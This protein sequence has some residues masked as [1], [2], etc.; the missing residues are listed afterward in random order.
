ML[1]GKRM[2]FK[3]TRRRFLKLSGISTIAT[4]LARFDP[5]LAAAMVKT[6]ETDFPV[7]V[8]TFD[9]DQITAPDAVQATMSLATDLGWLTEG[10]SVFVKVACNSDYPPPSVTSPA[11]VEGVVK[12]LVEAGAGTVYVG[13]MSG[14]LF[15]RH[16]AER[17]FGSTRDNLRQTG[18]LEAAESAGAIIHCFEEVPFDEAYLPGIPEG[19]HHWGEDLQVAAILDQVDHIINL[20]RL[21]KH[22]LAGMTLGMKSGIGWIS[23]YSRMVLHRDADTFQEKI[24]EVNAIPQIAEKTRLTMTLVDKALTTYGPDAGYHLPLA[25]P[26]VIASEDVVSHDQIA[27]VTLLW[28]RR[29]T[30]QEIR[31]QVPYPVQANDFNAYFVRTTW[32][33]EAAAAYKNLLTYDDLADGDAMTH[34]NYAF[35]LL[36]GGRPDKIEVVPS[37]LELDWVLAEMLIAKPELNIVICT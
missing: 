17:G 10:D 25:H 8:H 30:P 23:D 24:A 19:D 13:D 26:L 1:K 9:P 32:G 20:P 6:P 15:V 7:H 31:D 11:V 21:G 5:G 28:G 33:D 37:G 36:H 29:Q 14:A 16:L 27:L 3:L 18:I 34:I 22:V 4:G 12:M 35:E 2:S